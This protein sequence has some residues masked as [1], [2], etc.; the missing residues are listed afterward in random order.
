MSNTEN[1]IHLGDTTAKLSGTEV[2][3]STNQLNLI[4]SGDTQFYHD[5]LSQQEADSA[6]FALS[7]GNEI[8]YQQ[9]HHM[10]DNK[11]NVLPWN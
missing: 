6:F 9:W 8:Q 11:F 4:G 2:T 7:E 10:S 1:I 5:F 3:V